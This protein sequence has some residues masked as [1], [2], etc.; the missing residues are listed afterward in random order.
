MRPVRH[1]LVTI[2]VS[3]LVATGL[4]GWAPT[5]AAQV[6][7]PPSHVETFTRGDAVAAA[8]AARD[9]EQPIEITDATS[10]TLRRWVNPDGSYT[11]ELSAS[12]VRARR[13]GEWVP[14]DTALAAT[15]DGVRPAAT[16][17][18]VRFSGGGDT[19]L[20][21]VAHDGIAVELTWPK[22]LPKPSISGNAATYADVLP[23]VDLEMKAV[24]AGYE[25]SFVLKSRAAA[26]TAQLRVPLLTQ[27][28]T[29]ATSDGQLVFRD[30]HGVERAWVGAARMWDASGREAPV[31]VKVVRT[32]NGRAL[33]MV[34]D[35]AFMADPD[36]E[37]PVT[38]DP[39]VVVYRFRDAYINSAATTTS[40]GTNNYLKIGVRGSSTYISY[41]EFPL[42]SYAGK[43]IT[44]V[45]QY[46]GVTDSVTCSARTT[47]MY[48]VTTS[49]TS[50]VTWA[51]HPTTDLTSGG[52]LAAATSAGGGPAG[53]SCEANAWMAF[54]DSRLTA[55]YQYWADND[56]ANHGMSIRASSTD[57][58][59]A[60]D[61]AS[62]ENSSW[63]P[64]V[65]IT[66]NSYPTVSELELSPTTSYTASGVTTNYTTSP[67][68]R[69]D[70]RATDPESGAMRV[71]F[72]VWN[73]AGTTLVASG[74][75]TRTP[76][77]NYDYSVM[78]TAQ[79][80]DGG[81]TELG[82]WVP[83]ADL[84][85]GSAFKWRVRAYDYTDYSTWSA[86][87]T[88]TVDTTPPAAPSVSSTQY[89]ANQWNHSGGSGTFT[90]SST[91][92]DVASY[93]WGLDVDV[94]QTSAASSAVIPAVSDGWHELVVRAVDRA[95][96]LGPVTTYAFGATPELTSPF[97]G[98]QTFG[99]VTLEARAGA[100][101]ASEVSY[102]YRRSSA[103]QWLPIPL[104][105]VTYASTSG[106][107]AQWPVTWTQSSG[108]EIPPVL[109]WDV[110]RTLGG[111]DGTVL[112]RVCYGATGPVC[113]ADDVE[114]VLD[115]NA[116]GEDYAATPVGPGAVS[117]VTGNLAVSADDVSVSSYGSDLSLSRT[118]NSRTPEAVDLE[119]PEL[120]T[121]NQQDVETDT[122]GFLAVR[123]TVA[124]STAQRAGGA[125]S[126]SVTPSTA[127]SATGTDTYASLG[128]DM[129]GGM[130]L[131]MQAGRS[132]VF[133]TKIYVP[134]GTGLATDRVDRG[135][136]AV[137]YYKEA[138]VSYAT[139]SPMPTVTDQ[140]VTLT[141]PF[142]V[143]S[144]AT[145]A[146]I[147]LYNGFDASKTTKVVYFDDST[148]RE[149]G[150]FGLGWVSALAVRSA[151]EYTGLVDYGSSLSV[152]LPDDS[153]ITF[154]KSGSTYVASGTDSE[155]GLTMT[156]GTSGTYGPAS[157]SL[158]DDDDNVV[159]FTPQ[160]AL[161]HG[162][163]AGTPNGYAVSSVTQ[164][165]SAQTTSY[166]YVAG[167]LTQVLAPVPSA[168]SCT[169]SSSA[170]TWQPGCRAL[171]LTYNSIG[172][173]T[174]V[175]F[176]TVDPAA[177]TP[178]FIDVACYGYTGMKLTSR[179]DPRDAA[180]GSGSRPVACGTP[181]L[182]TSYTYDSVGRLASVADPGLAPTAFAY[183]S[184]G[185]L[186]SA[187]R[188]HGA[189]F[190]NGATETTNVVYG[191]PLTP[192]SSYPE[193]RPDM[194]GNA[195][196]AWAQ[197][198][199]PVGATAVYRP[200]STP[201]SSDLRDAEVTY[202]DVN[203]RA[204]NTAS[205]SGTGA[206]GW[207]VT[208]TGYDVFGRAI[209]TLSA[210]N[211]ET[212]L[213]PTGPAGAALNLPDDTKLAATMLDTR[214]FLSPTTYR[215]TDVYGPYHRV[216]FADGTV[217]GARSH[218]HVD[219]DTGTEV[220]HPGGDVGHFVVES[221]VSASRSPIADPSRTDVDVDA[222]STTFEYAIDTTNKEGWTFKRPL[223]TTVDPT[224]LAIKTV[225]RYDTV[226]GLPTESWMPKASASST[227]TGDVDKVKTRTLYYVAGTHPVDAACGSK[228]HWVNLACRIGPKAQPGVTGLPGLPV[229]TLTYDV[230]LRPT[231]VTKSVTSAAGSTST[232]TTT[233]SYVHTYGDRV[234]QV[235]D[236]GGDGADVPATTVS[237][238]ATTGLPVT[239]ANGTGTTGVPAGTIDTAY[240]D[241]GRV[242]SYTDADGAV[243][244]RTYGDTTGKVLSFTDPTG[245]I[246]Y[247]YGSSTERRGM[248]TGMTVSGIS[249][250][251][252]ATYDSAGRLATQ[253][254]PTGLV[255]TTT[256][257]ESGA[258]SG[259]TYALGTSQWWSELVERDVT[260]DVRTRASSTSS[261][262]FAHDAAGRLVRT[263]D[264]VGEGCTVR[265][266]GYD[267]HGNRT[268][269]TAYPPTAEGACQAATGGVATARSHDI[270]DRLSG[271]GTTYDSWGRITELPAADAGG[272]AMTMEYFANAAARSQ[273]QGTRTITW[274]LD[275]GSRVRQWTDSATGVTRV[276]HYADPGDS[277]SWIAENGSVTQ[278]TRNIT[279][280][281]GGLVATVAATTTTAT[282]TYQVVD[283]HGDVVATASPAATT[284]PDG[285]YGDADEF[286]ISRSGTA[287]R[288][289]WLGGKQRSGDA[290]GGT[291]LMGARV[292]SPTLGRFV[293]TDPV[294]GG[295]ANA[296]DYAN[297]D[298][299]NTFDLDG[300]VASKDGGG[301]Q[302][303]WMYRA[304]GYTNWRC[305]E[306]WYGAKIG[307]MG[308][309]ERHMKCWKYV[310]GT[311]Q[312][313]GYRGFI[314]AAD[315][316]RRGDYDGAGSALAQ[317]LVYYKATDK[318]IKGLGKKIGG[319]IGKGLVKGAVPISAF[320][321][322]VDYVCS[323]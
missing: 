210:D 40:Y 157:Y 49:W 211:R 196:A 64:R 315:R 304:C 45:T 84:A 274:S 137:A 61:F 261:Q 296:Y 317:S 26:S 256:Y 172:Y 298:P 14:I 294:Q 79:V 214:T 75:D 54:N 111:K 165:G 295:S 316:A 78:R 71:D 290:L 65:H 258:P 252:G 199:E 42:S 20:A 259:L 53:S 99:S 11:D 69:F 38:V 94:P 237:Y 72:E 189:G 236:T 28:V 289:G 146:W 24:A 308:R 201:S 159:V 177:N 153:A 231:T 267:A 217:G 16:M 156:A 209:R 241:F 206:S 230:L 167:R 224:G 109:N 91:A 181:V 108:D 144:G 175:T 55:K 136:R 122:T 277:P 105:D 131:G 263:D 164:P 106:A 213:N 128:G 182:A 138:G 212:A 176:A 70:A 223:R 62:G 39:T 306:V 311:S 321:T 60:K 268:L 270:V 309:N 293:Q 190:N 58:T 67:R 37:F 125:A 141:V 10:E 90:F 226:T 151:A 285:G 130:R 243:T 191:V 275:P 2:T 149:Q 85:D 276:N 97:Y 163:S 48:H 300:R 18:E 249:G 169:N 92:T 251:F 283:L 171:Q 264:V 59:A 174:A 279:G 228:P 280:F 22:R 286:G 107:V 29:P 179:W 233:T 25:Q 101:A 207:H 74:S 80:V 56:A 299:N 121:Q 271:T 313:F 140:W 247:T 36:L 216:V 5:A 114:L 292:Y 147:R 44:D 98:T 195:V 184:A 3:A 104:A 66:Y 4:V 287:P 208:T 142:S 46:L 77:N 30:A 95:G 193:H 57:T 322:I 240:D 73:S 278:W 205:Y 220:G 319:T 198:D 115:Q 93:L 218:T 186:A 113:S 155:S 33:E 100:A 257:D 132:Y 203:G 245:T 47:T 242:T 133:S 123:T 188:T 288:Y 173:V 227:P 27:G 248:P 239:V 89:P 139:V 185:R 318:G 8:A 52:V 200:G 63:T 282:T 119:N 17:G 7:E 272:S 162:A 86:W 204:V 21:S 273:T 116:F 320:A 143:P 192:D 281:D 120:L 88:F 148:L 41:I 13:G 32:A 180:P 202:F 87:K 110:A 305:H 9:L 118:A 178:L 253:T 250:S 19:R 255:R 323:S 302:R 124:R 76:R 246:S 81:G 234:A 166:T 112:V 284:E 103:D 303:G 168:G 291:V 219:Y 222:R 23:G 232:H 83:T 160:P 134:G 43:H 145:E 187:S 262:T 35:A 68:P 235:D 297:Q 244:S 225:N 152:G 12:P 161:T 1:A 150:V 307:S 126:L 254:M 215:V 238:S 183:D 154:V 127:N 34:P 170:T 96:H 269:L 102:Q 158:K 260:G 312:V 229:T 135:L 117:L 15:G 301:D 6:P 265:T 310:H 82:G 266:Y 31:A 51:T 50:N 314:T 129:S 197:E 194:T 221:T